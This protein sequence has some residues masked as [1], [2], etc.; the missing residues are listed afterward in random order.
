[1]KK[2][3]DATLLRTERRIRAGLEKKIYRLADE[4]VNARQKMGA[5]EARLAECRQECASWKDIATNLSR[6]FAARSEGGR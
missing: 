2:P 6:D 1:M 5:I 3:S 4:L